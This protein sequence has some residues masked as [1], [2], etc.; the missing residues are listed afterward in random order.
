MSKKT[1]ALV[2]VAAMAALSLTACGGASSAA[3]A[4][5]GAPVDSAAS[6]APAAKPFEG[7][8]LSIS[9]F[10]F[11]AELLQKNIYDPFME[12]TGAKLVVDTGKN[13]ERVTKI[14]ES[15]ANY[16]VVVIGD[17]FVAQLAE[18]GLIDTVD[19][20]AM[21]N[22]DALYEGA[23]APMGDDFGPA[24]TFNRLG[25]VYD[26]KLCNVEIKN[27]ADL[28]NPELADS[29][30]IP[31]ITTTTGP[32]FYYATAKAFGL[33]PGKDDA[34]IFAK[35]GEL[36]ANVVKTYTSANDT[37]TMLNQGEVSVAVLL[38]YSYTAAKKANPDYV[39]VDPAEGSFSGYN[40]LNIVKGSKNKELATAFID[41]YL[42]KEVQLAEA[43][44][45][46]DSPVRTDVELTPDQAANF[47]YGK[48][49]I[50]SLL[51]IDWTL[52]N[53][54][55]AQWIDQWNTIFSVK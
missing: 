30:A 45:G 4:S 31:D 12:A 29:I 36:K 19:R 20:S 18:E 10:S 33:E 46:V 49:T 5:S 48:D 37:I 34:A 25:I 1:I 40:M 26:A 35:L 38:D 43:L 3:P 11:N 6:S 27:W 7:Q 28:W 54:N 15:P 17:L 41:F 51:F 22:L 9:T 23:K 24:Y 32:L 14:K 21:T 53:A 55:K 39:W 13:A 42:S 47:T 50:D 52:Y 44:D 2:L 8:T 16:D